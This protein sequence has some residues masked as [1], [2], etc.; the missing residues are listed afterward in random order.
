MSEVSVDDLTYEQ[1][2]F[3]NALLSIDPPDELGIAIVAA[4]DTAKKA[5]SE[6]AIDADDQTSLH[7]LMNE[8][9]GHKFPALHGASEAL[10][11]FAAE[12]ILVSSG[13]QSQKETFGVGVDTVVYACT[14]QPELQPSLQWLR[15]RLAEAAAKRALEMALSPEDRAQE[16][17]LL[18]RSYHP[19]LYVFNRLEY[20]LRTV[21]DP[22]IYPA[23]AEAF[24]VGSYAM[25]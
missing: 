3:G 19:L 24:N 13:I 15:P 10:K 8:Y 16:Q 7:G 14:R 11:R 9:L 20:A 2:D 22:S 12:G 1:L 6:A 5:N 21:T 4:A 25:I 17:M 18:E 23:R